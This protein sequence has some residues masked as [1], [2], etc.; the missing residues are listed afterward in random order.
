VLSEAADESTLTP[1][2]F[3]S[4]PSL[5]HRGMLFCFIY[6]F[7][8][9][10]GVI[11][12]EIAGRLGREWQV[13]LALWRERGFMMEDLDCCADCQCAVESEE[14]VNPEVLDYASRA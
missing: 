7:R 1:G 8:A 14:S 10:F 5:Q 3:F 2:L 11:A 9:R 4:G 12:R 6:K 13:P